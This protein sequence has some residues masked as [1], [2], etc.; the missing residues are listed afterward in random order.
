MLEE[1]LTQAEAADAEGSEEGSRLPR[2]LADRAQ[3]RARLEA[4]R[5]T[6]AE[7][8][9]KRSS[10]HA[11]GGVQAREEGGRRAAGQGEGPGLA[12]PSIRAI[13]RVSCSLRHAKASS[14]ATMRRRP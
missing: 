12:R 5:L 2:E 1:L 13:P 4:A 8:A 11:L 3:R 6:L 10:R 14:K 9:P 7:L